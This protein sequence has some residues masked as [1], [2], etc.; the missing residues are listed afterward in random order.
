MTRGRSWLAVGLAGAALVARPA[1]AHKGYMTTYSHHIERGEVEL[2]LLSDFASPSEHK[3]AEEGQGDHAAQMMELKYNPTDRLAL[4][5]MWEW[6]KDVERGKGKFTGFRYEGRYRLFAQE[7]PLNPMVY[8]EYENLHPSTRY[9]METSGWIE[10][11]YVEAAGPEPAREK[12][13][14][15][16]MILSQDFGPWNA[17]FNWINESDLQSGRH[18]FGYTMGTFYRIHGDAGEAPEGHSGHE[19]GRP[20]GM[21]RPM[22][23]SFEL[24]GALGDDRRF[25]F[26]PSRQEHYLQ[27][28]ITFHLGSYSML[29]AGYAMG[30]SR[31]SDDMIRLNVG[32]RF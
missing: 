2:M 7:V 6:F 8:A 18:A 15:S 12:I 4:E 27:P 19:G 3:R 31:S 14:E 10:P 21:V 20:A 25:G 17:S 24:F 13:L 22:A 32:W 29:T 30:L 16:R 28:G 26:W 5:F 9:K 11:P 23:V 1:W